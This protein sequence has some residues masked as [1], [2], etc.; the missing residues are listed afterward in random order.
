MISPQ[1]ADCYA[2]GEVHLVGHISAHYTELKP[3]RYG[4]RTVGL[5]GSSHLRP[6]P[7]E[8]QQ[9]GNPKGGLTNSALGERG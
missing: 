8:A 4:C 5:L 1:G 9:Q 7:E 3:G 2:G 6:R